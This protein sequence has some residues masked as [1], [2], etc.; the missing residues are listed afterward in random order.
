MKAPDDDPIGTLA[1]CMTTDDATAE[2]SVGVLPGIRSRI[3][4]RGVWAAAADGKARSARAAAG[5]AQARA[6]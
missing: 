2:T 6:R 4:S 3:A 1:I 5:T